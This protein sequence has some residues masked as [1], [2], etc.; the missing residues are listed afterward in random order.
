[1]PIFLATWEVDRRIMVVDWLGQKQEILSE[2]QNNHKRTRG[3]AQVVE[4]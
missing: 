3:V 2:K 1:M 4:R